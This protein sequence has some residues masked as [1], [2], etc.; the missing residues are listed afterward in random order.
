VGE[1]SAVIK[2]G[3]KK[4]ASVFFKKDIS[5][6]ILRIKIRVKKITETIKIFFK[7]SVI[8]YFSKVFI[9]I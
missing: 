9:M 4:L 6:K 7:N 8:K 3:K 5:S 2:K 1:L